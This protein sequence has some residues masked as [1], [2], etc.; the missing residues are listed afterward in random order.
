MHIGNW[1]K[2]KKRSRSMVKCVISYIVFLKLSKRWGRRRKG[3]DKIHITFVDYCA[4]ETTLCWKSEGP[5]ALMVVKFSW[6]SSSSSLRYLARGHR[7]KEKQPF[8]MTTAN[9][10]ESL[11]PILAATKMFNCHTHDIHTLLN[12]DN[13]SKGRILHRLQIM[14][15]Y[16]N[17]R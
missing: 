4:S 11:P 13:T 17:T 3:K 14:G 12:N 1:K 6:H 7:W 15:R 8:S 16:S 5:S 10:T 9:Y 2:K